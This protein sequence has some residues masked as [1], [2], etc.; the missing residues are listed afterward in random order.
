MGSSHARRPVPASGRR[1]L[2]P[3]FRARLLATAAGVVMVGV[4]TGRSG[5]W[6]RCGRGV[7]PV[8]CGRDR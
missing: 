6:S 1:R 3:L 4:A 5:V 8:G 7:R 2:R